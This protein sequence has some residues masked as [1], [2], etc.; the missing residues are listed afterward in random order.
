ML[1]RVN[2][3]LERKCE[4]FFLLMYMA[5]VALVMEFLLYV[6]FDN[7]GFFSSR[8]IFRS[9]QAAVYFTRENINLG[10]SLVPLMVTWKKQ[11][12]TAWC[13]TRE[14]ENWPP[15]S[16]VRRATSSLICSFYFFC[17]L[18]IRV[19]FGCFFFVRALKN[20]FTFFSVTYFHLFFT[21]IT[22]D[23]FVFV[24]LLVIFW[25]NGLF[26]NRFI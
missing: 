26:L 25:L 10:R 6:F 9:G 17:C 8:I 19:V 14:H 16:F 20:I 13:R 21:S 5:F 23:I 4:I 15:K 11:F 2:Q 22:R 3:L 7:P 1:N 12:A 18:L 24:R